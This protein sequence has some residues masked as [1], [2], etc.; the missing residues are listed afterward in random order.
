M[1]VFLR[2][3]RE[4]DTYTFSHCWDRKEDI[5]LEMFTIKMVMID[6]CG[7]E[8]VV[9]TFSISS[10]LDND[11]MEVWEEMKIAK[12]RERYPEAYGFYFE[13]SREIKG[14]V[15]VDVN[16]EL[17]GLKDSRDEDVEYSNA[18]EPKSLDEM[19]LCDDRGVCAGTSCPMYWKCANH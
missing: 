8:T 9:D 18:W 13:D 17:N 16:A 15:D 4:R 3:S 12:A 1:V 6:E 2:C 14:A 10:E 11:Y 7:D 19:I 5:M